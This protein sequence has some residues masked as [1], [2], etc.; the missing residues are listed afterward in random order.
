MTAALPPESVRRLISNGTLNADGTVNAQ[1]AHR[2]GWD[3]RPDWNHPAAKPQ[4]IPQPQP[5]TRSH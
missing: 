3:Q 4:S 1:T 5:D 2:L